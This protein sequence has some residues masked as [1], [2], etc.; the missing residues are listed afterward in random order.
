MALLFF[1]DNYFYFLADLMLV[2]F[3]EPFLGVAFDFF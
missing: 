1:V 3:E 2:F